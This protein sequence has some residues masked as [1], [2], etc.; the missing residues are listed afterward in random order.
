[1][2]GYCIFDVILY[3]FALMLKIFF[4]NVFNIVTLFVCRHVYL[5]VYNSVKPTISIIAMKY[6][7]QF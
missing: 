7:M 3:L 2:T 4:A 1:M 5:C 6:K